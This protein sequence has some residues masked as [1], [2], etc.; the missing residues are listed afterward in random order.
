MATNAATP[1]IASAVT[2]RWNVRVGRRTTPA[3]IASTTSDPMN[4]G[5]P[6]IPPVE[7]VNHVFASWKKLPPA[8]MPMI[9]AVIW[10][11]RRTSGTSNAMMSTEAMT[12]V[13]ASIQPRNGCVMRL[14]NT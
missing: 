6:V 7:S 10:R 9:L 4:P 14:V 13:H 11:L 2:T 3:M 5:V 12:S 8:P 1:K